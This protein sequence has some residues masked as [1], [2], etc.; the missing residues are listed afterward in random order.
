MGPLLRRKKVVSLPLGSDPRR[1][2]FF[3]GDR[4]GPRA[5]VAPVAPDALALFG[6]GEEEGRTTAAALRQRRPPVRRA[7]QRSVPLGLLGTVAEDA[8]AAPP[9]PAGGPTRGR[10]RSR[11]SRGPDSFMSGIM[12]RKQVSLDLLAPEAAEFFG[13][14]R[15]DEEE[16]EEEDEEEEEEPLVPAPERFE[17]RLAKEKEEEEV[18]EEK[19]AAA[20]DI[21]SGGGGGGV[22]VAVVQAERKKKTKTKKK[23]FRPL[24]FA[25]RRYP[26]GGGHGHGGGGGGTHGQALPEKTAAGDADVDAD[27]DADINER[28]QPDPPTP[29]DQSG[30]DEESSDQFADDGAEGGIGIGSVL[31]LDGAVGTSVKK[32]TRKDWYITAFLVVVMATLTGI[33][34]GWPTH[35]DESHSAFGIVGLACVTPCLGNVSYSSS[36]WRRC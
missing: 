24:V 17:D 3:Y 31:D 33:I 18:A 20:A 28:T 36:C 4:H 34:A 1:G 11:G 27:A 16:E 7:K 13:G 32:A 26:V 23:L 15:G 22:H 25:P 21:E 9:S 2:E 14:Y 6:G 35:L 8:A 5:S 29:R 30:S 12:R 10:T 19:G